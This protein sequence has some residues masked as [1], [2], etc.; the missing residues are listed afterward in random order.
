MKIK[1]KLI[2][3]LVTACLKIAIKMTEDDKRDNLNRILCEVIKND[4]LINF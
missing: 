4:F 2:R 1:K 3:L